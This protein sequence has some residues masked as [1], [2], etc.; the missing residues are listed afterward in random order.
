MRN[1]SVELVSIVLAMGVVCGGIIGYGFH[2]RTR[3]CGCKLAH[4]EYCMNLEENVENPFYYNGCDDYI[5]TL[6]SE[7]S[8]LFSNAKS[9]YVMDYESE[10]KVFEKEPLRRLPIASM[11]KIMTLILTFD[12]IDGGIIAMDEEIMVSENA[13]SMGGSQVFLEANAKYP[14]SELIKSIVVCSAND[15]CVAMAERIAGN[16]SLFVEKMNNKA[17]ELGCENTLFANCTGL[18]KEPQYSCA[19]DVAI[20][21]KELL[22]HEDY[23][24][25]GKIW[26]DVF[27]H[28]EGRT[29]EIS[30]T[31]RLVRF[32]DGCDGGKTGFTN[33]AG[34]CLAATAKRGEMRVISVV[35][36]ETD[37]KTR[38]KEVSESFD[39]AFANYTMQKVV[40]STQVLE[41]A[42]AVSG[43]KEKTL[44]VK[45]ARDGYLFMKR[46]EKGEYNV[47]IELN[48]KVQAPV[49]VGQEMGKMH[50][51]SK[52]VE[53]DTIP[54]I[55]TDCIDKAGFNDIFK[56]IASDWNFCGR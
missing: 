34:F 19:K 31:N 39:Y 49:F 15:S 44:S 26:T 8:A 37:S 28:P 35:I 46:G 4:A 6:K 32:Y 13:A 5:S 7:N 42:L 16:D 1:K 51:Y 10:T 25:F 24:R 11:C 40:D 43:G 27:Q 20:M 3:K 55:S 36:G 12:A 17:K 52:G 50:V 30:N 48:D 33:E 18:P 21:L 45:P 47:E 29:T 54:L 38:F 41:K 14:V 2:R 22:N 23:Y 56:D 9:A 53:I